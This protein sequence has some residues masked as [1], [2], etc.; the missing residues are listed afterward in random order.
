MGRTGEGE[1]YLVA[2]GDA[3][4]DA[5]SDPEDGQTHGLRLAKVKHV[6]HRPAEA[7]GRSAS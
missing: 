1:E 2:V 3:H 5:S 7:P 4:N 6:R